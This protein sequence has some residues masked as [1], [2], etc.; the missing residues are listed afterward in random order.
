MGFLLETAHAAADPIT[1]YLV[2]GAGLLVLL[3]AL[4]FVTGLGKTRPHS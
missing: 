1:P 4:R 3:L 2:G